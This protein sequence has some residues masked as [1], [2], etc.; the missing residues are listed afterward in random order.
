MLPDLACVAS[1]QSAGL[2]E[3]LA[4][5]HAVKEGTCMLLGRTEGIVT[6][7]SFHKSECNGPS[8]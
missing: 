6:T 1:A 4:C 5:Q 3:D 2:Q 7:Q 8:L